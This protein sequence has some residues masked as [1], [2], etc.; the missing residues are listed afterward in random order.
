MSGHGVTE[1]LV[2]V[3]GRKIKRYRSGKL[4]AAF[5]FPDDLSVWLKLN[6]A[7]QPWQ[8]GCPRESSAC[9]RFPGFERSSI[10]VKLAR[11]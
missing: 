11:L 8:A 1:S 9:G 3:P 6:C 7:G 4:P 10:E 2:T 5:C